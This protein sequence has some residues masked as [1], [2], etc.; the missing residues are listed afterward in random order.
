MRTAMLG[1]LGGALLAPASAQRA[2]GPVELAMR[3]VAAQEAVMERHAGKQEVDGLIAFYAPDYT[4]Y[5]P[6][7][8]AKVTGLD[9][10]RQGIEAHLGETSAARIEIKGALA[11]GAMVALALR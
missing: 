6:Q 10:V 11:N 5:H 4:Y 9:T 8:G 1:I 3:Y 7:F 2:A